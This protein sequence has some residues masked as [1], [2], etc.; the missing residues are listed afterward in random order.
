CSLESREAVLDKCVLCVWELKSPDSL[1]IELIAASSIYWPSRRSYPDGL[2]S[3]KQLGTTTCPPTAQGESAALKRIQ[4]E[5]FRQGGQRAVY[6]QL[7]RGRVRQWTTE[8]FRRL[9]AFEPSAASSNPA[10]IRTTQQFER[11]SRKQTPFSVSQ[12]TGPGGPGDG[13][14]HRFCGDGR[15]AHITEQAVTEMGE[16]H[17]H[18]QHGH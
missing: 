1:L 9:S 2:N 7:K 4:L 14:L 3:T 17:V 12:L 18:Y 13:A 15:E 8:G 5:R 16:G 6:R 10:N 11:A